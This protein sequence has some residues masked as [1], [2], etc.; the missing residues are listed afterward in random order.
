MWEWGV[1]VPR[2]MVSP[3]ST[4]RFEVSLASGLLPIL[5]FSIT[6]STSKY[7]RR[8]HRIIDHVHHGRINWVTTIPNDSNQ[9]WDEDQIKMKPPHDIMN[10]PNPMGSMGRTV[11]LPT[12][13]LPETN[14]KSP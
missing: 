13:T 2:L 3:E 10:R 11:Y 12:F 5:Y 9:P 1:V 6:G 14:S 8:T 7:K 4:A